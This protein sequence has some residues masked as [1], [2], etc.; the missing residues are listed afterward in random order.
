M[1]QTISEQSGT[2]PRA[3]RAQ[4]GS[5]LSGC[6]THKSTVSLMLVSEEIEKPA[7]AGRAF[8]SYTSMRIIAW[9]VPQ[10]NPLHQRDAKAKLRLKSVEKSESLVSRACGR[11]YARFFEHTICKG[12]VTA[13]IDKVAI[14]KLAVLELT[15]INEYPVPIEFLILHKLNLEGTQSLLVVR[16]HVQL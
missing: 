14:P 10:C 13:R 8:G 6:R 4:H 11:E 3:A 16:R 7:F 5:F 15:I 9:S 2:R 12:K 1:S